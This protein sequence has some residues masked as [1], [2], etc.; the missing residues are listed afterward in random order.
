MRFVVTSVRETAQVRY[1]KVGR[2][3]PGDGDGIRIIRD[4]TGEVGIMRLADLLLLFWRSSSGLPHAFGI[5]KPGCDIREICGFG[6]TGERNDPGVADEEGCFV[7]GERGGT[8][9][10]YEHERADYS[11]PWGPG[12]RTGTLKIYSFPW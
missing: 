6:K 12:P 2:R 11:I 5:R 9:D 4:G 8:G 3:V 1:E 7:C 10:E